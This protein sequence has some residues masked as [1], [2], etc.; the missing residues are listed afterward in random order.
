MT[1]GWERFVTNCATNL[2]QK[3]E[4]IERAA[5]NENSS[6]DSEWE[7]S[8]NENENEKDG[9]TEEVVLM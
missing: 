7:K 6:E 1:L 4:W 3:L 8:E 2:N 5:W 9:N